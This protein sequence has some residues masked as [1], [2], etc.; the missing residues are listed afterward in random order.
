MSTQTAAPGRSADAVDPPAGAASRFGVE[1]C[2][3]LAAPWAAAQWSWVAG[4]LVL[5]VLVALPATFNVPGD[6]HHGGRPVSGSV[7]IGIEL[8]LM[9]AAVIGAVVV[10]PAWAVAGVGTMVAADVVVGLPRWTWL[11]RSTTTDNP[12]E[13]SR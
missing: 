9:T 13:D 10:W 2:A 8:V 7:R 12:G 11:L 6:K 1:L 3:W 4:V 5:V